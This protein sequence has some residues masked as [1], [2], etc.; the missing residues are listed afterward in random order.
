MI[1]FGK[2]FAC[3]N[4]DFTL[5]LKNIYEIS[6][7]LFL[8]ELKSR[9]KGKVLGYLWAFLL[10]LSQTCIY[11]YVF[12]IVMKVEM[13]NFGVFMVTG[14]F[15]WAMISYA[16]IAGTNSFNSN[17]NII[18]KVR[19][20]L[21]LLPFSISINETIFLYLSMLIVIPF[22]LGSTISLSFVNFLYLP[23]ISILTIL[24]TTSLGLIF[25]ILNSFFKDISYIVTV[26]FNVIFFMTPI[27]YPM[28]AV[29]SSLRVYI[30]LNPFISFI[31]SWR[32]IFFYGHVDNTM[33]AESFCYTLITMLIAVVLYKKLSYKVAEYA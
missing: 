14:I 7:V 5:T 31:E 23:I 3:Y 22:I 21:Y 16:T 27:V 13:E 10:P 18:K 26:L 15:P 1:D 12:K 24:F 11:Y 19:F 32:G 25:A 6:Y 2:K 4:K 8:K 30:L 29:P 33:I 20:P 28:S 17:A 9:Y